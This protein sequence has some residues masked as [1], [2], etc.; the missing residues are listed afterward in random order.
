AQFIPANSEIKI[1]TTESKYKE[2]EGDA[3]ELSVSYDM[4]KDLKDGDF[5]L[6]DDGKLSAVV[7]KV[8]KWIVFVKTLNSHNLKTNKRINLPGVDFSLPFLSE[9]D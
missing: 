7:T 3:K 9:K 4:S 1:N 5:V 8:S 6:F 2:L